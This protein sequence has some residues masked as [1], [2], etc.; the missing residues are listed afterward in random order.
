[1]TAPTDTST[2]V[3]SEQVYYDLSDSMTW[4]ADLLMEENDALIEKRFEAVAE[5]QDR[6]VQMTRLYQR[7]LVTAAEAPGFFEN[8]GPDWME[9][10]KETMVYLDQAAAENERLLK[11]NLETVRR[12]MRAVVEAHK[13]HAAGTRLYDQRGTVEA[14]GEAGHVAI[15][16]NQTL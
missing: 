6:K 4:L 15:A 7:A 1:M 13:E 12:V 9:P 16:F 5:L 8:L 10:L 14:A 11:M 3:T 2:P